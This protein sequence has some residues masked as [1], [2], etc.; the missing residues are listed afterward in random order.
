M[1]VIRLI[2]KPR[3]ERDGDLIAGPRGAK[4]WALLGRLVRSSEPISRQRLV[5]E[6]FAEAD[7]PMAAL[8]WA[9]AELRRCTGLTDAF[10]GNPISAELGEGTVIDVV[11]S[12]SDVVAASVPEGEFLEGIEVKGSAGF[13]TWLLIERQRVG[14]DHLSCL[15]QSTLH[16]LSNR[17][18]DEA[19]SLAGAMVRRSPCDEGPHVLLIKA[20]A[21]SGDAHAA[22]RQ[23]E[24]SEAWFRNE[25]GV[26]P[27]AAI[28]GAARPSVAAPVPGTS[29]RTTAAS[30]RDAGLAA[31]SAGAADAGIEC[32]R[33]AAAAAE[34]GRDKTLVSECL[35]ELGTALV[36]SIR[37]Y[38]DE[39][40]VVLEQAA[41]SAADAR[42]PHIGAKAL[43]ELAYIDMLAGRRQSATA[44]LAAASELAGDDPA[45]VAAV[46]GFEAMNLSDWGKVDEAAVR[47]EQAVQLSRRS[48]LVRREAWNLGIGARTLF[49]QG[50]LEEAFEWA[51]RSC[52]LADEEHWTAFRPWPE[53]WASHVRLAR[54]EEPDDVRR[55]AEGTF[56][57]A[58]QLQDPCWEGVAA[59]V[60]GLTYLAEDRYEA[61]MGWMEDASTRCARVT[62]SYLWVD[63]E[64]RAA[65][66]EGALRFGDHDR[67]DSAARRAMA[68]AARGGMDGLLSRAQRVLA[69]VE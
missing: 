25:L 20:L 45:L 61:A 31:L 46:A 48:G 55:D 28:R 26:D 15:R 60:L 51:T 54:G 49:I 16:A 21:A 19:V 62:D 52:E 11:G 2:G 59:E 22:M 57:V 58:R 1:L 24:A 35:M 69:G 39:G 66:A 56:T 37:G 12:G 40:S 9:L 47:F 18:Y 29:P 34:T 8:R 43:S 53:V 38:D 5:S 32:L 33:G 17:R 6:L 3:L 36:H 30:L 4:T 23:V 13:D 7:D 42:S 67:A 65:E 68:G 14:A 27:S 64:I 41:A 50:R 63:V 10:K 44:Y